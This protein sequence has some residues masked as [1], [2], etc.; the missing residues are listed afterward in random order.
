M[1]YR[2][3]VNTLPSCYHCAYYRY[4]STSK[5]VRPICVK[6]NDAY[7]MPAHIPKFCRSFQFDHRWYSARSPTPEEERE[8]E[9]QVKRAREAGEL[10]EQRRARSVAKPPPVATPDRVMVLSAA[11]AT[12]EDLQKVRTVLAELKSK[13]V[14]GCAAP[15][16]AIR[17]RRNH[18]LTQILA[19][20]PTVMT[21]PALPGEQAADFTQIK[22]SLLGTALSLDEYYAKYELSSL[23]ADA[24][25]CAELQLVPGTFW[26]YRTINEPTKTSMKTY[27][28]PTPIC[29]V[30]PKLRTEL[31]KHDQIYL[32]ECDPR[33][34]IDPA[35]RAYYRNLYTTK[36]KH[37]VHKKADDY[38]L[39]PHLY[40]WQVMPPGAAAD[41]TFGVE[42]YLAQLKTDEKKE[43]PFAAEVEQMV[44][45]WA[46]ATFDAATAPTKT[47]VDFLGPF[48]DSEMRGD[49]LDFRLTVLNTAKDY[50]IAAKNT[51]PKYPGPPLQTLLRVLWELGLPTHD[52]PT[53]TTPM[54]I[55]KD[56]LSNSIRNPDGSIDIA[57]NTRIMEC[58]LTNYQLPALGFADSPGKWYSTMIDRM[59][60]AIRNDTH[61]YGNGTL[62]FD[63]RFVR[64]F[65]TVGNSLPIW[66]GDLVRAPKP[67]L[68]D[69]RRSY[70]LDDLFSF[71]M[72]LQWV[73]AHAAT[74]E[75]VVAALLE[76]SDKKVQ[77]CW[78]IIKS[79]PSYHETGYQPQKDQPS[80]NILYRVWLTTFR[81][82]H[83]LTLHGFKLPFDVHLDGIPILKGVYPAE[84]CGIEL[85][86]EIDET[87]DMTR[88]IAL[89]P[90]PIAWSP[91][92]P[93]NSPSLTGH[94]RRLNSPE[95]QEL[96]A[97]F[98]RVKAVYNR[99][100]GWLHANLQGSSPKIPREWFANTGNKSAEN[101]TEKLKARFPCGPCDHCPGSTHCKG[102]DL[103]CFCNAPVSGKK[104]PPLHSRFHR[105]LILAVYLAVR[106][107][108]V[109]RG[110][111]ET[112]MGILL[113][114]FQT[115]GQLGPFLNTG[116]V[117]ETVQ[118]SLLTAL[119]KDCFGTVQK[120]TLPYLTN[121]LNQLKKHMLAALT[122]LPAAP[123][124]QALADLNQDIYDRFDFFNSVLAE[125][126]GIS[127]DEL[128]AQVFQIPEEKVPA[129]VQTHTATW[130]ER[131]LYDE[132]R[133]TAREMWANFIRTL[134]HRTTAAYTQLQRRIRK[135]KHLDTPPRLPA[136]A[137][138]VQTFGGSKGQ[139]KSRFTQWRDA[140]FKR[141]GLAA[142]LFPMDPGSV[143]GLVFKTWDEIR[144]KTD[145]SY[146]A[147]FKPTFV[148][149]YLTEEHLFNPDPKIR[150]QAKRKIMEQLLS[151]KVRNAIRKTLP[152]FLTEIDLLK[153]DPIFTQLKQIG[154]ETEL[155]ACPTFKGNTIPLYNREKIWKT[156]INR[157]RPIPEMRFCFSPYPNKPIDFFIPLPVINRSFQLSPL[158]Y[159]NPDNDPIYLR[160]FKPAPMLQ[161]VGLK[162]ILN[163][164]LSSHVVQSTK[165]NSAPPSSSADG[166]IMGVDLGLKTLA[167]VSIGRVEGGQRYHEQGRYFVD[168]W[169][170]FGAGLDPTTRRFV[171]RQELLPQAPPEDL[172]PQVRRGL[173]RRKGQPKT[174]E[175]KSAR[176]SGY[177]NIKRRLYRL[178]E[179]IR[180]AQRLK[181]EV[182][183]PG[184]KYAFHRRKNLEC[185]IAKRAHLHDAIVENLGHQLI[186]IASAWGVK[187]IRF[188]DL[189][190]TRHRSKQERG[191]WLARNQSHMMHARIQAQVALA[192][193]LRGITV[194]VVN[195][196]YT[197]QI[198]TAA[199]AGSPTMEKIITDRLARLSQTD[200]EKVMGGIAANTT[201]RSSAQYS[202]ILPLKGIR[203]RKVFTY[204]RSG[205]TLWTGDADL[206]AAR[207]IAQ[208]PALRSL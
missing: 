127:E 171:D 45:E 78:T 96:T 31:G 187:E 102:F 131:P 91:C 21:D 95:Q 164:P 18:F 106:N 112:I 83:F 84:A 181:A 115:A 15:T 73:V 20:D 196:G 39:S 40:R 86:E 5:G 189:S 200:R 186:A 99:L 48:V 6:F 54:T 180:T 79:L 167:T 118:T 203:T 152:R 85:E 129:L 177:W 50:A 23:L 133:A 56:G 205:I 90:L 60:K 151:K 148:S 182:K 105:R 150:D 188:E 122:D 132:W 34:L 159:T 101:L 137:S 59:T 119:K 120:I 168:Q 175:M 193:K 53:F 52:G 160:L 145:W 29:K 116:T 202:R 103:A 25:V 82:R 32:W 192:G 206:N 11:D 75:T 134:K 142:D 155:L 93:P 1:V 35:D 12:P 184:T 140:E 69:Q 174:A 147:L 109:R 28:K 162:L 47:L 38:N 64:D 179:H 173:H 165:P 143:V 153:L 139:A 191:V 157:D 80:W 49:A 107:A 19:G 130:L 183:N 8:Y 26:C 51:P 81:V 208:R 87:V 10:L 44:R 124:R 135:N 67:F 154:A 24:R 98:S 57:V 110:N 72:G 97:L 92:V 9:L 111:L 149:T 41:K 117:S 126:K 46:N 172:P 144:L 62:T 16:P 104:E 65:F 13:V 163:Q 190:W 166:L 207:N 22:S 14:V 195:A 198:Y 156:S 4:A 7:S 89:H 194:S 68:M 170:L 185:L 88:K 42:R 58:F 3:R 201:Y 125:I 94:R 27:G 55:I 70:E 113:P 136:Y 17:D 33:Y 204:T 66:W 2:D 161:R 61:L 77:E 37:C 176:L 63:P 146:A 76:L 30:I 43:D 108:V 199:K 114:A 100:S 74:P 138:F 123:V 158:D 178:E 141:L 36:T 121:H 169:E 71:Y 128:F 197:S